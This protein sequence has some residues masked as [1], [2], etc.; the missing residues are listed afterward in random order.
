M[1]TQKK[2]H[3]DHLVSFRVDDYTASHIP[4]QSIDAV[5]AIET[6]C[7]LK[8]TGSF[9][10]EM[11]RI[12]KPGGRL[13]VADGVTIKKHMNA[14]EED[15]MHKF[16]Y[17]W[18]VSHWHSLDTHI[19]EMQRAGFSQPSHE[20]YSDKT[21][22]SVKR[23]YYLSLFGIPLYRFLHFIG[24]LPAIRVENAQ[25]CKYQWLARQGGLW[26]HAMWWGKNPFN[27]QV[28]FLSLRPQRQRQYFKP[29]SYKTIRVVT[30]PPFG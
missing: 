20:Y 23:L 9:Y 7:H 12:L 30:L 5:F 14:M 24:I 29:W 25:S 8:D 6:I 1:N 19:T 13:L 17:G 21:L 27:R 15:L 28:L 4:A 3:L 16:T 2:K 18:A 10:K 11:Y 22:P 26:G